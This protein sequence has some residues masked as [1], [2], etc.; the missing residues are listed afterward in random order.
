MNDTRI[1]RCHLSE[2]DLTFQKA[3]QLIQAKDSADKDT[4][5]VRKAI[6]QPT[7]IHYIQNKTPPT[8][9]YP[10][11]AIKCYRV[12]VLIWPWSTDS[13]TRPVIS[14]RSDVT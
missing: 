1:Q 3:F 12:V 2:S 10:S 7:Q 11:S 5:D 13:E 14:V 8:N 6:E 9:S 4:Q